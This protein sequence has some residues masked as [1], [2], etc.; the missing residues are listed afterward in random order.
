MT[1]ATLRRFVS[2]GSVPWSDAAPGEATGASS[3]GVPRL[4]IIS[5]NIN[6]VRLRAAAVKRL[7]SAYQP[8]VLC[9]Q[10]TKCPNE[11]FPDFARLGY[12]HRVLNGIK[13]WHGVAILSKWVLRE[14]RTHV[15]CQRSDGRHISVRLPGGEVLHNFYVPAG[16]DVPDAQHNPKFHHKLTFLEEMYSYLKRQHGVSDKVIVS[17]DLNIAPLETDVWSHRSLLNTVC[18]TPIEVE[19]L[20]KIQESLNF[21]D[22]MRFGMEPSARLYSWWSYRNRDWA[23]SNRGRRLDHIWTSPA[24]SPS[25][26]NRF[27]FR[28]TRSWPLPSDHIPA[29]LDLS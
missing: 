8:D 14:P 16:G 24:L 23:R 4:R 10:E 7:L 13:G 28:E 11:A 1:E 29:V 6:S 9:L 5:W 21:T 27:Y 3:D 15:F 22:A 17:G 12:P 18:H 26:L 2:S 20:K 19:A 25:I